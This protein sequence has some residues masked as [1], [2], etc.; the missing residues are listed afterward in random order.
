MAAKKAK[1]AK[2]TVPVEEKPV[3]LVEEKPVPFNELYPDA[4]KIRWVQNFLNKR[5]K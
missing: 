3:P 5:S 2:K 1:K 4:T